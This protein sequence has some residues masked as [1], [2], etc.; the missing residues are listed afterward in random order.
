MAAGGAFPPERKGKPM[1]A[2]IEDIAADVRESLALL[3]RHL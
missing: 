1:R 3:G 2:E